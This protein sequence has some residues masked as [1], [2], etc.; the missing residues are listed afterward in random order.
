MKF[1]FRDQNFRRL[2]RYTLRH[3]LL[4]TAVISS[5]V[6]GFCI[7]FAF[8]W[9]IGSAIDT[10]MV[11]TGTQPERLHRLVVLVAIGIAAAATHAMVGYAR[12]HY[13]IRLGDAIVARLRRDLFAH[14]QS[15][16]LQFYSEQRTGSIMNRLL[17]DVHNATSIIYGGVIVVG[18]DAVQ[19]LVAIG[20]LALI[21]WK[22]T[23]ACMV[24]LPCYLLTFR[25]FN[26]RVRRASEQLN[27][28]YS[29][30]S[31]NVQE[32]LSGIALTQSYANEKLESD[33]FGKDV[34]D[35]HRFVLKQSHSAH[36]V[37]AVSEFL[38]H[39]GTVIV[40][41]YGAY[42]ALHRNAA[43]QAE[44]SIG[45]MVKFLGYLGIM[46]GPL[47]RFA[48]LNVTYQNSLSAIQRI[49]SLFEIEPTIQRSSPPRR[50]RQLH[51]GGSAVRSCAVSLRRTTSHG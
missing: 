15:Q 35:H 45:D 46:Y 32:Q 8:P 30:F 38:V 22:L 20:L 1:I 14:L 41:G 50:S 13:T 9:L 12:G 3:R 2:L 11:S 24:V 49:F 42:L 19:L 28:H 25:L 36:L 43:G 27:E 17:H 39:L 10:V 33:K 6:A 29:Y 37:G 48:D 51:N 34:D 4:L 31:G 18:I 23:L 26:P 7:L 40:F 21:S 47:R 5:G 16:S 44:L